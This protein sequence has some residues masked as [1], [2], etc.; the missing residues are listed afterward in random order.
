MRKYAILLITAIALLTSCK[1]DEAIPLTPEL[2]IEVRAFDLDNNG[3]SSD[4]RIDFQ[5]DN[6]LN[7]VEYRVM[8]VP[9]NLSSSFTLEIAST[10]PEQSYFRITPESFQIEYSI[11]RLPVNLIDVN[12]NSVKNEV[13]YV[14]IVLTVGKGNNQ[15]SEFSRPFTLKD[16]GIYSGEYRG[17][18]L[19]EFINPD[20]VTCQLV[21]FETSGV[22]SSTVFWVGGDQ[23]RGEI[24]CSEL[25]F[26]LIYMDA[27]FSFVIKSNIV[28]NIIVDTN[29]LLCGSFDPICTPPCSPP[30][31][32]CNG[33]LSGNEGTS[34][35]ELVLNFLASGDR[36][37][38][39][40]QVIVTLIRQ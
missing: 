3:N 5:V 7:V 34:E 20:I 8:I 22:F 25:D 17:L 37:G 30:N 4:I 38:L 1:D 14:G 31:E 16:Q 24:A 23:Y 36:C 11:N 21:R 10:I 2:V 12:G 26:C 9:F 15:L 27:K 32:V 18:L 39:P 13:E 28:S 35:N 19:M 6:N 29:P 33:I 40:L